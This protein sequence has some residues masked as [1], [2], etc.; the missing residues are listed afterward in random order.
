MSKPKRYFFWMVF[1]VL[2]LTGSIAIVHAQTAAPSYSIA[3]DNVSAFTLDKN[4]AGLPPCSIAGGCTGLVKVC[5]TTNTGAPIETQCVS[6]NASANWRTQVALE[7]EHDTVTST[8]TSTANY[9]VGRILIR[10][11][12]VDANVTP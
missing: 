5:N 1:A 7:V 11:S 12:R 4:F 8:S 9:I 10:P 3:L 6:F 2:A